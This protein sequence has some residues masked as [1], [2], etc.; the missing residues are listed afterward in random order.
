[1]LG[2]ENAVIAQNKQRGIS[3]ITHLICAKCGGDNT[4]FNR[5]VLPWG[6]DRFVDCDLLRLSWTCIHCKES[7]DL[8]LIRL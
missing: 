3:Q 8:G 2:I 4:I 5:D 7:Y 1:M 6:L